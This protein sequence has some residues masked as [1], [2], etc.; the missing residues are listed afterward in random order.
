M[1]A[2]GVIPVVDDSSA[3]APSWVDASAS[4]GDG[5]K[6]DQEHRKPNWEWGKDLFSPTKY[7]TSSICT[8]REK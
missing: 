8:N 7:F 6:V 4:D 1:V 5:G 2:P 3:K